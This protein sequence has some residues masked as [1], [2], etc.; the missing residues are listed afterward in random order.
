MIFVKKEKKKEK[1]RG[2]FWGFLIAKFLVEYVKKQ[3]KLVKFYVSLES[4]NQQYR[5]M[6]KC[7]YF[8]IYFIPKFE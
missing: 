6:F 2:L 5:K 4:G 3:K 1:K 7:F 8:H